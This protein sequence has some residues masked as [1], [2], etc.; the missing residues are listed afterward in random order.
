MSD[1][2]D[3]KDKPLDLFGGI[4]PPSHEIERRYINV[5][6]REEHERF[7]LDAEKC[8]KH[9]I[10]QMYEIMVY[11]KRWGSWLKDEQIEL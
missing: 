5:N 1:S 4:N 10:D 8:E 9:G 11:L 7:I 2:D 3:P 6:G